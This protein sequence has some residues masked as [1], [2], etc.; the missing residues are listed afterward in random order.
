MI[1]KHKVQSTCNYTLHHAHTE[2]LVLVKE[3]TNR[4]V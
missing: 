1:F 2:G 3:N 4:E